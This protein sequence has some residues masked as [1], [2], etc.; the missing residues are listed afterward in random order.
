MK[1]KNRSLHF[2]C[3]VRF[4][5]GRRNNG[6]G[7]TTHLWSLP[8]LSIYSALCWAWDITFRLLCNA[9]SFRVRVRAANKNGETRHIRCVEVL[10][11]GT[12]IT[13]SREVIA[14][15]NRNVIVHGSWRINFM[16]LY[17]H[18]LDILHPSASFSVLTFFFLLLILR[19]RLVY[20]F[21]ATPQLLLLWLA[22]PTWQDNPQESW[23]F[24]KITIHVALLKFIFAGSCT[25]KKEWRAT[26]LSQMELS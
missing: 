11:I 14:P 26:M 7:N 9:G 15:W 20:H 25:K 16:I 8:W 24:Y 5:W 19:C 22:F 23:L 18:K 21:S 13:A 4:G 12:T 3:F 10:A 17:L 1:K 6:D 2:L